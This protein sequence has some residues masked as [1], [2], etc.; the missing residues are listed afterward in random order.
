MFL[1]PSG[2]KHQSRWLTFNKR[3]SF[4]L[5]PLVR[6]EYASNIIFSFRQKSTSS[7]RELNGCNSTWNI[8]NIH[9]GIT[10]LGRWLHIIYSLH[11]SKKNTSIALFRVVRYLI[12][13]GSDFTVGK[14]FLQMM[15]AI[16]T[17]T[18]WSCFS[19]LEDILHGLPC[20]KSL[21]RRKRR[22]DQV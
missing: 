12:Y 19:T 10:E 9:Q 15:N 1:N 17:N 13:G 20:I 14:Q 2:N 7:L 3:G 21:S 6:G 11:T 5:C 16:I 8:R 22:M 18:D 4:S